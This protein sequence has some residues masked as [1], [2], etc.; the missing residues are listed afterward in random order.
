MKIRNRH[1]IRVASWLGGGLARTLVRSVRTEYHCVGPTVVPA[2]AIPA[3]KRYV[4]SA[5]HETLLLPALYFGHPDVAVLVSRH[6]DGQLLTAMIESTGMG[7]V[8]GSTNRGG[9]E[10][11]RQIVN[12]TAGR[13]HLIVT[14]DGPRGP[15]RVVQPGIVYIASR[16][17]MQ[18]VPTGV[19]YY[20]PWRFNSWDKFAVPKPTTKARILLGE[21]IT[22]PATVKS[23]G[24]EA[25][26]KT[27]Q[28]EMDRL[29]AAAEQWAE[30]GRLQLPAVALAPVG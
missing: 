25:Y 16:A 8:Q 2:P 15:R 5:W 20:R 1:V 13:K 9:I 12:G 19:G 24:L 3:D 26:R 14:T 29:T 4:F 22:V 7:M 11:V 17:G 27:V 23:D 18:I 21:P 6:A 28:A 30:T 10:A